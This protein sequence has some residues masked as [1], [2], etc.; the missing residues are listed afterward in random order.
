MGF[1]EIC[2][3]GSAQGLADCAAQAQIGKGET[4]EHGKE[5]RVFYRG[6][7]VTDKVLNNRGFMT[8]PEQMALE[9]GKIPEVPR[10]CT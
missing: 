4:R 7:P 6:K 2:Q 8:F 3:R 9:Q 10:H 1:P 5:P